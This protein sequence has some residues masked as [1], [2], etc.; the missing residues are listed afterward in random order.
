MVQLRHSA[1][2]VEPKVY[3]HF[4]LLHRM[5]KE[6]KQAIQATS[7]CLLEVDRSLKQHPPPAGSRAW[8]LRKL[9]VSAQLNLMVYFYEAKKYPEAKENGLLALQRCD[10][11]LDRIEARLGLQEPGQQGLSETEDVPAEEIR[12]LQAEVGRLKASIEKKIARIEAILSISGKQVLHAPLPRK[13]LQLAPAFRISGPANRADPRR[14]EPQG[15]RSLKLL[16]P[17]ASPDASNIDVSK[18]SQPQGT[19]APERCMLLSHPQSGIRL[20]NRNL[21][22][23]RNK[24]FYVLDEFASDLDKKESLARN[25]IG[26]VIGRSAA[27]IYSTLSSPRHLTRPSPTNR[28]TP[29]KLRNQSPMVLKAPTNIFQQ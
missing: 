20:R 7:S 15:S 10:E 23:F 13:R 19:S 25:I 28:T 11:L 18:H 1:A 2:V 26:K 16:T 4:G 27:R 8:E 6:L 24:P 21:E 3:L 29:L 9:Q 5:Q 17:C 14:P 22:E 12:A